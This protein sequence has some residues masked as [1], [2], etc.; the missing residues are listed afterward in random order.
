M[1]SWRS[2]GQLLTKWRKNAGRRLIYRYIPSCVGSPFNGASEIFG[3][4]QVVW[5]KWW[6][7]WRALFKYRPQIGYPNQGSVGIVS[8]S[9]KIMCHNWSVIVSSCLPL[10]YVC[11][12][13]VKFYV[14]WE[15]LA[16]FS[17]SVSQSQ[18]RCIALGN[19]QVV[20]LWVELFLFFLFRPVPS[21]HILNMNTESINV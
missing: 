2:S 17:H 13:Q 14:W 21:K 18:D 19:V 12:A 1:Q 7:V 8:S 10:F 16:Q 3:L 11:C 20:Y 4:H 6:Y 9:K 5:A 15:V